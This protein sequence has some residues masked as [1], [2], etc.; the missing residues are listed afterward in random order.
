M[1]DMGIE[2]RLVINTDSSTAKAIANRSGLGKVRHIETCQLWVQQEVHKGRLKVVKVQGKI[3]IA[4]VMTK[5]LDN[6]TLNRHLEHMHTYRRRDRHPLN[7]II[8][9]DEEGTE[10]TPLP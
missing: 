4:D 10:T 1:Q 8:A 3:N 2:K 7:P 6:T 9:R 5:H